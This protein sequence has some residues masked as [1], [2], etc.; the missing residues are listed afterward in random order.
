M[1]RFIEH[2]L[3]SAVPKLWGLVNNEPFVSAPGRADRQPGHAAAGQGRP[4]AIYLSGWQVAR[5]RQLNNGEMYPDQ[6]L[7]SVDSVPKVVRK[8]NATFKA[9][10]PDPVERGKGRH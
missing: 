9:R 4:K 5:R 2:T 1:A 10:R 6:S 7:Y 3:A 8:I